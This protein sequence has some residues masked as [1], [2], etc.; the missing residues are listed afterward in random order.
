MSETEHASNE[1]MDKLEF[2]VTELTKTVHSQQEKITSLEQKVLLLMEQVEVQQYQ[3]NS[4]SQ[5]FNPSLS[6]VA[7]QN[8]LTESFN[9]FLRCNKIA[10]NRIKIKK[11]QQKLEQL[12]EIFS[13]MKALTDIGKKNEL[14]FN[15][16]N[17]YFIILKELQPSEEQWTWTQW[18]SSTKQIT[19]T[20]VKENILLRLENMK[21]DENQQ[22]NKQEEIQQE[23]KQENENNINNDES[24]VNNEKKDVVE[25]ISL[26]K[27]DTIRALHALNEIIDETIE[28]QQKIAASESSWRFYLSSK[29]PD[30]TLIKNKLDDKIDKSGFTICKKL[31]SKIRELDDDPA[32][33]IEDH[34]TALLDSNIA[35]EEEKERVKQFA[36]AFALDEWVLVDDDNET[37]PDDVDYV[38]W[39]LR[40]VRAS[41]SIYGYN[42]T[43]DHVINTAG[44]YKSTC[45]RLKTTIEWVYFGGRLAVD[46]TGALLSLLW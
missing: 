22:E 45:S 15:C 32:Q 9:E 34:C 7:Q 21:N 5:Q 23:I 25:A 12:K 13:L 24:N 40:K 27:E 43:V 38:T 26:S 6:V 36:E 2:L 10:Q 1:R 28:E 14:I 18:W 35:T 31:E 46:P 41:C 29:E 8:D 19:L 20:D 4:Q 42:S 3:L 39:S 17:L 33:F 16:I 30:S 11:Q 44:E 37:C